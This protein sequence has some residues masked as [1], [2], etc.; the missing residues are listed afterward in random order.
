MNWVA[1]IS[2]MIGSGMGYSLIN[3]YGLFHGFAMA[4]IYLGIGAVLF[5]LAKVAGRKETEENA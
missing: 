1:F 5:V 2:A 3:G 4:V